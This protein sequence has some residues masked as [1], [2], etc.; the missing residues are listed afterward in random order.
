[1]PPA[2]KI[3]LVLSDGLRYDVAV[4]SMGFLG[5]LVETQQ[6]SLYRVTGELP[7]MSRPMY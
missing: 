3:I 6:A 7:T 4:Q 2:N 1:M 5:H